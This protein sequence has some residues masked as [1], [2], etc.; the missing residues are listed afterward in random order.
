MYDCDQRRQDFALA[1]FR[2]QCNAYPEVDQLEARCGFAVHRGR[3]EAAARVL[4]CPVKVNPP[5]W[6]HGRVI[7]AMAGR[8]LSV[9]PAPGVFVDIGTAKGFSAV[10]AGW[11][12]ELAGTDHKVVSVDIVDPSL[13]VVRNSVLEVGDELFTVSQFV[14]PFISRSVSTT[15][16]GGGSGPTLEKLTERVRFAFVDGKHS[17]A[18]VV[19]D[20][21]RLRA[22]Q[23][24]G[25]VIVFDD[26]QI[27]GVD[28]AVR[29]LTGYDKV[30]LS[31]GA[32]R[33][34]ALATRQ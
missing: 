12:I 17:H 33:Q 20:A 7:Y 16:L 32:L 8:L 15:F 4:A 9:D 2:E 19:A 23:Q 24:T 18:A 22:R 30:V 6:Q 5:S 28:S 14:A 26:V 31:A 1:F 11:A 10:V 27:P 34:Y 3:L 13:R 25:D 29:G 21:E